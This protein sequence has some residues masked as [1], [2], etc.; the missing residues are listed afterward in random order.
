[1]SEIEKHL[2][3]GP[4]FTYTQFKRTKGENQDN[5]STNSIILVTYQELLGSYMPKAVQEEMQSVECTA[6]RRQELLDE[7]LGVLFKREFWRVV[8]DEAHAIKNRMSQNEERVIYR[9]VENDFR[10]HMNAKMAKLRSEGKHPQLGNSDFTL[11]LRLR[12]A[13][14]HPFLLE[15]AIKNNLNQRQIALM[16]S[17]LDKVG[18]QKRPVYKQLKLF[19]KEAMQVS[20]KFSTS[21]F[22]GHFDIKEQLKTASDA[23]NDDFCKFCRYYLINPQ[24]NRCDHTFCLSCINYLDSEAKKKGRRMATCPIYDAALRDW[25]PARGQES[26]PRDEDERDNLSQF[27]E[28]KVATFRAAGLTKHQIKVLN[29]DKETEQRVKA[30]Q[31]PVEQGMDGK[32]LGNDYLDIQPR[33]KRSTSSFLD[34]LDARYPNLWSPVPRL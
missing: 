29:D 17:E 14:T 23:M 9:C 2:Q 16:G 26:A 22:G 18:L 5:L 25:R 13:I 7:H 27:S 34:A 8:L 19:H 12:Q 10:V 33:S 11:I 24:A 21:R 20:E 15:R 31:E 32:N 6:A 3:T 1:M 30:R 28:E 4:H